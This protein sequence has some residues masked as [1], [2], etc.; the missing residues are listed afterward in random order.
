MGSAFRR[1]VFLGLPKEAVFQYTEQGG[2]DDKDDKDD[3]K[4]YGSRIKLTLD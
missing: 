3:K 4:D 2:Q 1:F